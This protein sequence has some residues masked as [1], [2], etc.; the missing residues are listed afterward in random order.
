MKK[1]SVFFKLVTLVLVLVFVLSFTG[2]DTGKPVATTAPPA[3]TT[4]PPAATTVP[5]AKP[6]GFTGKITIGCTVDLTSSTGAEAGLEEKQGVELAVKEINAA[7]GVLGKELVINVQDNQGTADGALLAVQ[8]L[9]SEKVV[10]LVGPMYSTQCLAVNDTI[11]T[12]KMPTLYG[13]TSPKLSYDNLKNNEYA[14][15]MRPNDSLAGLNAAKYMVETLGAKKI[16]IFYDNDDFGV[17]GKTVIA[18][19]L[20]NAKIPYELQGINTNDK[21]CTGSILAFKNAGCDVVAL[22]AHGAETALYTTQSASLGYDPKVVSC[23]TITSQ[24][25]LALVDG[26][27]IDGW[28]SVCEF[29]PDYDD[30]VTKKIIANGKAAYNITPSMNYVSFYGGVFIVADAIT[31]AGSTE[32]EAIVTA[33]KATKDL[34]PAYLYTYDSQHRLV[35]RNLVVQ[36]DAN[37]VAHTIGKVDAEIK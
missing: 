1:S 33:L 14:F 34:N 24:N 12:A 13:G 20:D 7:G 27:D 23:T 29:S 4:A 11:I 28:Y 35:H 21:D 6:T 15:M 31:R 5:T 30:A 36:M 37:K 26:A 10:A 22:W 2:C 32:A 9:I 8:K 17:G 19:Y 3:A 18:E 16:G 25:Y